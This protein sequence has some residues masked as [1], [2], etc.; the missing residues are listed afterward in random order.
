MKMQ[1]LV[2]NFH[3]TKKKKKK[4]LL[5]VCYDIFSTWH[6]LEIKNTLNQHGDNEPSYDYDIFKQNNNTVIGYFHDWKYKTKAYFVENCVKKLS[7]PKNKLGS[8]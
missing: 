2:L 8:H 7:L 1:R 5:F 6:F 3:Y 4:L